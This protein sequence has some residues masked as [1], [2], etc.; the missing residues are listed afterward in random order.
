[1]NAIDIGTRFLADELE[2]LIALPLKTE[3]DI[4]LWNKEARALEASLLERFPDFEYRHEVTH[5]LDDSSIRQRDSDYRD[6]QH[7]RMS[8][9]ITQL[10][11]GR[12][13]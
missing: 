5:F 10:R 6:S 13:V 11:A 1:M 4:A 2:R 7:Q 3:E 12:P 8:Q 9:Y